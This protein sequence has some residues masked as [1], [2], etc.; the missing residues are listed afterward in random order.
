MSLPN[1]LDC[2]HADQGFPCQKPDGTYD[3]EKVGRALVLYGRSFAPDGENLDPEARDRHA[4]AGDC[5]FEVEEEFPALVLPLA[6]AAADACETPEDAAFISAG[7][8]ENAVVKHGPHLIGAIEALAGASAKFRYFLSGVWSQAGR[9]DDA[10]WE[11]LAVA[12]GTGGCMDDDF[13]AARG[14]A[15]SVVLSHDEATALL[16][17]RIAPVARSLGLLP[18]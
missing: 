15:P 3:F 7:I 5:A 13:R 8:L 1:C 2:K 12:I 6:V 4:W 16:K 11:R 18:A 14:G 9:V 17:E 10:V